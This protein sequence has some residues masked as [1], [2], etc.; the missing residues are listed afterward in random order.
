MRNPAQR[1]EFLE[2]FFKNIFNIESADKLKSLLAKAVA[3]PRN[4]SD[5]DIYQSLAQELAAKDGPINQF[6]KIWSS[7][8]QIR[9]QRK[10][11]SN[12]TASILHRLGYLGTCVPELSGLVTIGD[13][14][15]LVKN[16]FESGADS[17]TCLRC[18]HVA[19]W[20][21]S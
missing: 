5:I 18:S 14:G 19:R 20:T 10:E 6:S 21:F 8:M 16:L 9:R 2:N 15:K 12:E 17:W 4:M 11:L 13:T 1:N 7:I 3:D